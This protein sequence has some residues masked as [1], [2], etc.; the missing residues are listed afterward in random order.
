MSFCF[1]SRTYTPF[2]SV[3]STGEKMLV[4]LSGYIK[5]GSITP[6]TFSADFSSVDG[7]VPHFFQDVSV[8]TFFTPNLKFFWSPLHTLKTCSQSPRPK[9]KAM[10][11]NSMGCL[12]RKH[13]RF[14]FHNVSVHFR[15]NQQPDRQLRTG[16]TGFSQRDHQQDLADTELWFQRNTW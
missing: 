13:W 8:P 11:S 15:W 10:E 9:D 14:L 6:Q 5:N 1:V 4:V 16:P 7:T 3:Q 12:L 2:Y